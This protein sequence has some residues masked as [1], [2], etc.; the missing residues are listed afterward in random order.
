MDFNGLGTLEIYL[1]IFQNVN[2]NNVISTIQ[3]SFWCRLVLNVMINRLIDLK[4]QHIAGA[5]FWH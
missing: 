2:Q 4:H 3:P 1:D 5:F